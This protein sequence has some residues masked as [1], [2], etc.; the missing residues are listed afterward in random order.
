MKYSSQ[1]PL[2]LRG[3]KSDKPPNQQNPVSLNKAQNPEI[4]LNKHDLLVTPNNLRRPKMGSMY[5]FLTWDEANKHAKHQVNT[6]K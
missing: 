2:V 1:R 4:Y 5:Q 6:N 3:S